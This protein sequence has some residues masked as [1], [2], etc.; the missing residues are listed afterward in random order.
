MFKLAA[1]WLALCLA[2]SVSFARFAFAAEILIAN[3]KSEPE[4]ITIAP[5]GILFA[6]SASTPF[7]Y[8]V[9][10]GSNV[11][12]K[13]VDASAEGPDTFFF[14]VLADA[15]TN[16][17]WTC[18]LTPVPGITPA[19]PRS[20]LR[21]FDLTTGSQKLRWSLPGANSVCNDISIGPDRALYI[22]DTING[23]IYW[24]AAGASIPAL[25]MEDGTL[26]K[27]VDG[28]TFLNGRLYVTNVFTS[29]L[30]RIPL[31]AAGKVGSPVEI[32][33]DR[34]LN[35]PDGMRAARGKLLLADSGSGKVDALTLV[36]DKAHVMVLKH[37]LPTPTAVEP[38]GDTLWVAERG[39][40]KALSIRLPK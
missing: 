31:N 30:Y 1:R 17:L 22:T 32:T 19:K 38:S 37:G 40:G 24:L 36:G 7:I 8:K 29:K 13:F 6:G 11:A 4:S 18:Q 39:A 16:T 12:E 27:G 28:I 5:G 35:A 3:V 21:G 33:T 26:F 23:R 20:T 2:I 9:H 25:L 15:A 34:P 14:G 10:L